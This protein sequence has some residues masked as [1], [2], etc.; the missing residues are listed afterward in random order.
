MPAILL[1]SLNPGGVPAKC[2]APP[3]SAL[4]GT[5]AASESVSE[6]DWAA[7]LL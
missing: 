2:P 7:P 4:A 1:G 5:S 6:S 3:A